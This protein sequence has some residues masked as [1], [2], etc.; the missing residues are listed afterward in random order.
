[1]QILF[2]VFI[3]M[4][5]FTSSSSNTL[6]FY[7][8]AQSRQLHLILCDCVHAPR[9]NVTVMRLQF[10]EWRFAFFNSLKRL[11]KKKKMEA[12]GQITKM[13]LENHKFQQE[14]LELKQA[15]Q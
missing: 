6:N 14:I 13:N 2:V 5:S 1:M 11:E 15:N 7:L 12:D 4:S 10:A 9:S 3:L 8:N